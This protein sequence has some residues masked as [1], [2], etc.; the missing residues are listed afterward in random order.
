MLLVSRAKF[1]LYSILI[2]NIIY[3]I[4]SWP[5][6]GTLSEMFMFQSILINWQMMLANRGSSLHNWFM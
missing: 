4:V 1:V 5:I 6:Q 3:F 2:K